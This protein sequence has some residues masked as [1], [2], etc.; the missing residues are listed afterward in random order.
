M[1]IDKKTMYI[2]IP[3]I[4]IV[5]ACFSFLLIKKVNENANKQDNIIESFK[6][7][8]GTFSNT[9]ETIINYKGNFSLG[10]SE[11]LVSMN[12]K[13]RE[14]VTY[15]VKK[16]RFMGIYKYDDIILFIKKYT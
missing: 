9:A 14:Q 16:L 13:I 10:S 5:A 6:N 4:L 7:N 1:K 12:S 15:I 3:C 2:L 8:L 11:S